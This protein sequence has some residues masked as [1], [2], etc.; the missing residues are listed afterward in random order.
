MQMN[1]FFEAARMVSS[2]PVLDISRTADGY[3]LTISGKGID[4][5]TQRGGTRF[6]K[7]V[8]SII[9]LLERQGVRC[10]LSFELDPQVALF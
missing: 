4:L 9:S 3:F 7:S 5:T 6:F 10:R 2:V 8:S 1:E